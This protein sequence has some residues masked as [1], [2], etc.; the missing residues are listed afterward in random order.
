[1]TNESDWDLIDGNG[2]GNEV[3]DDYESV[4]KETMKSWQIQVLTER[5]LQEHLSTIEPRRIFTLAISSLL[6]FVQAGW[7]GPKLT[8]DSHDLLGGSL[9][10]EEWNKSWRHALLIDGEEV[11]SLVPDPFLLVLSKIV[12]MGFENEISQFKV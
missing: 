12:F 9:D 8:W 2:S 3:S 5:A 10:K 11:Y 7:T 6:L 4:L 1:M